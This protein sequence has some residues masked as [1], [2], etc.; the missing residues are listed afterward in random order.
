M[1]GF[2]DLVGAEAWVRSIV[3]LTGP[4]E[5]ERERAWAT[6]YRV[7]TRDGLAWFKACRPVQAF[8]PALTAALSTRWPDR[9]ARVLGHEPDHAWLLTADAGDPLAALGNPPELWER[10]LPAY[11]ELQRGEAAYVDDH[12]ASGVPDLRPSR[13]PALFADLLGAGVPLEPD[14]LAAARRRLPRLEALAAELD[15]ATIGDTLDHADLHLRSVFEDRGTLRILDWGDASI[16]SPFGSLVVTF[17]FL[18]E[19]NGLAAGDP[20]FG[21]LRDAYLEPWGSRLVPVF[22]LAQ[23]LGRVARAV[24]WHRHWQA[25]DRG[26]TSVLHDQFPDV[27]R[28]AIGAFVE[29]SDRETRGR[30]TRR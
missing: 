19:V 6:I 21:R 28:G 13:L 17:R 7:P 12:L 15:S 18:R 11:A 16:G 29:S 3:P 30:R 10:L 27:L 22:E 23:R 9:V 2:V 24:T 26:G 8:E 20:W 5:L 25:M 14:E 1:T 4:L